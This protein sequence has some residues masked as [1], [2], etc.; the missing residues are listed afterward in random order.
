[1]LR[2]LAFLCGLLLLAS[3]S[4]AAAQTYQFTVPPVD[5]TVDLHGDP[6]HAQ[7]V[8]FMAGNQYMVMPALLAAFR[9]GHPGVG[10]VYYE[11]LPPGVDARQIV[12]GRLQ[13]GN[14]LIDVRP[15][16]FM[17]GA[18]QM[19]QMRQHGIVGRAVA[20]A[21]NELAIMVRKGNPKRILSLRDLGRPDVRV[22]MPNPRWEG[23]AEQIDASYRK[24]GGVALE[25]E[26]MERKVLDG[27]TILTS[28]HHRQTPM[29]I[30]NGRADA[31]PVWRSEALYQERIGAP[32]GM[33]DVPAA[34][35]IRAAY[36]AAA[37]NGAQHARAA[38]AFLTFLKSPQAAAIYR[39]YGFGPPR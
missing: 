30:L 38:Q 15:D 10:G 32:I 29:F 20:Y 16:V 4:G 26:I 18:R 39:S 31:G 34:D 28:I 12:Q 37:V 14:L 25:R 8:V 9:R 19:Q 3:G 24:A 11:T 13:I 2:A 5:D 27:T 21:S 35:N 36:V 22:A 33:V 7:L 1:M 23:V 6:L 17:S